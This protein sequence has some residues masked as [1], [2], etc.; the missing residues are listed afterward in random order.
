MTLRSPVGRV[1]AR[2]TCVGS[3]AEI[4]FR[5]EDA[6][7][8]ASKTQDTTRA[9]HQLATAGVTGQAILCL[10]DGV[11]NER[12]A[13]RRFSNVR[14]VIVMLPAHFLTPGEV[15]VFG[16]HDGIF[17]IGRLSASSDDTDMAVAEALRAARI[18]PF[19]DADV[20][21]G[22]FGKLLVDL[23]NIVDAARAPNAEKV[24]IIEACE[25]KANPP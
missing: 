11:E 6:I 17:D 14:G 24:S 15:A 2:F 12:P 4:D 1:V 5:A 3:R 22:K 9:L 18:A 13:L 23:A 10:K 25:S 8:L 21:P 19:V 7:L 16:A 20:M